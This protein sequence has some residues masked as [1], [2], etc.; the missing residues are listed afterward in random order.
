MNMLDLH[1]YYESMEKLLHSGE[2]KK[3][4]VDLMVPKFGF[5]DRTNLEEIL[6]SLGVQ[7]CFTGM[8]DF[9]GMTDT[10]VYISRVLQESR[11][12]VDENGVAAAAYTLVAMA[13]G[14]AI[15]AEREKVDFH[16]DRPFLYAI[17]SRD[18]TV[19]FLGAVTEPVQN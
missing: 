1:F 19:L 12:D 16:L 8:A 9:S 2:N 7:T 3:A 5:Q 14:A 4:D 13:K 6:Q 18:G 15:P 10:P 17:E 11:I